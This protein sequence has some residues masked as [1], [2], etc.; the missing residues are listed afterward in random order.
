[1]KTAAALVMVA[2]AGCA[3]NPYRSATYEQLDAVK[4]T[5]QNCNRIDHHVTFLEEQLRMKGLSTAE[6]ER[7]N[8]AD[9]KYNATVRSMIWSLRIG[10][11]NPDR[12]QS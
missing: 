6:P 3:N 5:N 10:C 4:V 2:L 12:Y 11:N 9:R 7:L 1:M 8:D